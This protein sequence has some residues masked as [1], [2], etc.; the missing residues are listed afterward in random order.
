MI[1]TTTRT[2]VQMHIH[3]AD[4]ATLSV[5]QLPTGTT[6]IQVSADDGSNITIFISP[7]QA[8]EL[9]A[10]LRSKCRAFEKERTDADLISQ[11]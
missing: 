4:D 9:A 1:T 2:G 3:A 5:D 10:E 6:W 7:A 8:V 11:P